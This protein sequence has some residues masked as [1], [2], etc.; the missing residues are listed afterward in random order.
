MQQQHPDKQFFLDVC[1]IRMGS[2]PDL[3]GTRARLTLLL[4]SIALDVV[5]L[6]PIF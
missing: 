4:E 1:L 3:Q 2:R 6:I 5:D